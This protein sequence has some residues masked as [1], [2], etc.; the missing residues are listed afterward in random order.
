MCQAHRSFPKAK[1]IHSVATPGQNEPILSVSEVNA[2]VNELIQG[3]F[4]QIYIEGEIKDLRKPP[5]GHWYFMLSDE[6]SSLRCVLWAGNA[7]RLKRKFEDGELVRITANL[8][9]YEVRGEFQA[10]VRHMELAGEGA[11]QAAFEELKAKLSREGLFDADR[12]RP[13]PEFPTHIT[14]VTSREADALRD[15]VTNIHR[16]YPPVLLSL[17]P[18]SVQGDLAPREIVAAFE[19]IATRKNL[20]DVI[21]LTRGGGSLMDLAA[22][23]SEE[24]ARAIAASPVPVV[25]AVGHEP[26]VTISDFV[27]DL[28]A[29]TPSTAA[30]VITPDWMELHRTFSAFATNLT[31]RLQTRLSGISQH[32][33]TLA[34]TLQ[35]PEDRMHR[36]ELQISAHRNSLQT[37]MVSLIE[38][39]RATLDLSNYQLDNASGS[40]PRSLQRALQQLDT[41]QDRLIEPTRKIRDDS[42]S[43]YRLREGIQRGLLTVL[44]RKDT[45]LSN[46]ATSLLAKSPISQ[47]RTSK[48]EVQHLS[49]QLQSTTLRSLAKNQSKFTTLIRALRAVSPLSTLERGFAVVAQPD[50]TRWG[51]PVR[52]V[53]EVK[54]GDSLTA[55]VVDGSIDVSVNN[56]TPAATEP[57]NSTNGPGSSS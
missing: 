49:R 5:S 28:R 32:I 51:R 11:L 16:R 56:V 33:D 36:L 7:R 8:N 17:Q 13:I 6:R 1:E 21:V 41:V 27:A 40:A 31:N 35:N 10:Q 50:G 18:T 12:K 45:Q 54:T 2:Q 19:Q 53:S 42:E 3:K 20:P 23:N 39:A 34:N 14:I 55:H 57:D 30:E 4:P 15:V 52:S 44:E 9:I 38:R 43:V 26:D 46:G 37:R 25:S 24:V 22:F 29:A 47:I 48:T